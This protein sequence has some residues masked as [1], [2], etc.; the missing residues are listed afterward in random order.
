M[1][2]LYIVPLSEASIERV[3]AALRTQAK[4]ALDQ[5]TEELLNQGNTP[6]VGLLEEAYEELT[7][8]ANTFELVLPE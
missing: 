1:E 2:P 6:Y 5:Y 4:I 7:E 8:L 3:I